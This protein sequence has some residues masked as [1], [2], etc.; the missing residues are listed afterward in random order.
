MV[1]TPNI[2][3]PTAVARFRYRCTQIFLR[4]ASENFWRTAPRWWQCDLV[5]YGSKNEFI[6][7]GGKNEKRNEKRRNDF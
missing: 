6:W 1:K 3:R 5:S 2:H 4:V 7:G